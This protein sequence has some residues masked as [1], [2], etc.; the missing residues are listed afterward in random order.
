L[1]S[2]R[3]G[4]L[5]R[6][7]RPC[8]LFAISRASTRGI[9]SLAFS[10]ALRCSLSL[11]QRDGELPRSSRARLR[12]RVNTIASHAMSHAMSAAVAIIVRRASRRATPPSRANVSENEKLLFPSKRPTGSRERASRARGRR[13]GNNTPRVTRAICGLARAVGRARGRQTRCAEGDMSE[14]SRCV[15]FCR[16]LL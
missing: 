4:A 9:A 15:I 13:G 2:I 14:Y 12:R 3:A 10:G 16:F 1:S 8:I 11:V 7:N 5:A 6:G